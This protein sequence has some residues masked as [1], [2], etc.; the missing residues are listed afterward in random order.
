MRRPEGRSPGGPIATGLQQ[1]V[2]SGSPASIRCSPNSR[3]LSA[4]LNACPAANLRGTERRVHP[5]Q[6]PPDLVRLLELAACR[7]ARGQEAQVADEARIERHGAPPPRRR[8]GIVAA[9]IGREPGQPIGEEDMR[10]VGREPDLDKRERKPVQP[11]GRKPWASWRPARC[12]PAIASPRYRER[13]DDG[14]ARWSVWSW[15]RTSRGKAEASGLSAACHFFRDRLPVAS[16]AVAR[17]AML[18][19]W[20]EYRTALSH[21]K[22][23]A[24]P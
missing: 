17:V 3:R 19:R 20:A 22:W 2:H 12:A 10:V 23:T 1:G 6:R 7:E 8:L 11:V 5:Q 24:S 21:R 16:W 13:L 14:V 4:S 15:N 18:A 9:G